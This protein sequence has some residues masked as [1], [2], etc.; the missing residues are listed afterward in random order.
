MTRV[1]L[2]LAGFEFSISAPEEV[3]GQLR[4][5]YPRSVDSRDEA[6]GATARFRIH[7]KGYS[8]ILSRNGKQLGAYSRP[9]YALLALEYQIEKGVTA[10]DDGRIAIHAGAIQ[11]DSGAWL[12]AGDPDSGKTST[13]F[14]LLQL[15]QSFLCEE[16]SLYDPVT[17]F[18]HPYPQTLA[19]DQRY[20]SEFGSRFPIGGGELISLDEG[21]TRFIP[22]RFAASPVPLATVL[23][24]RYRAGE[25]PSI[26]ELRS[27]VVLTEVL[28]YCFR[29]SIDEERL[30]D[31]VIDLLEHARLLRVTYGDLG[32]ARDLYR[33]LLDSGGA[34]S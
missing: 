30:F 13:T 32:Q 2:A 33:G 14:Q 28:R 27:E 1:L 24:P 8:W 29:P 10:L 7:K 19:L 18:I 22:D 5:F 4:Q 31:V 25:E 6:S 9:V 17:R 23:L 20:V 3:I 34:H 16:I 11:T 12:V 21:I 26:L 15:E